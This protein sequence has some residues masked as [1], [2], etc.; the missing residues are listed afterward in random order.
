MGYF[1]GSIVVGVVAG[2]LSGAF[3]IGGG[4]IT[5]PAIRLLLGGSA[6]AAVATPLVAILPSAISGSIVYLRCKVADGKTALIVGVFGAL[7]SI[8]GALGATWVG[9]SY[10]LI[11]TSFVI[12]S[13]VITVIQDLR[14][15]RGSKDNEAFGVCFSR[16]RKSQLKA[17]L[18]GLIAGAFS[19][20]F[21]IGGGMIM[22]PMLAKV[23]KMPY[24]NA[25][26][27]SLSAMIILS[28]PGLATHAVL[29][30]VAWNLAAG[31]VIGVIPG[32]LIG[33]RLT[34]GAQ[35][36]TIKVG[37]AILL[38]TIGVWM[39]ASELLVILR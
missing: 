21:G 20:F 27:T 19:G 35:E 14:S 1:I 5:T 33:A 32:A 4:G 22:V 30:N 3:G 25:I 6:M 26:G 29:G 12:F 18:I 36:K 24:K 2:I 23:L 28:L 8:L 9:G 31:L 11:L 16:S 17:A 34:L 15:S 38:A 10:V 7:T 37:F 13:M 39:L